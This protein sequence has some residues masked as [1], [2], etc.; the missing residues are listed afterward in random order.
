MEKDPAQPH[1]DFTARKQDVH[2]TQKL[3]I[4]RSPRVLSLPCSAPTS[5]HPRESLSWLTHRQGFT[6]LWRLN[7]MESSTIYIV[8]SA[9]MLVK[10]S[11]ICPSTITVSRK[12]VSRRHILHWLMHDFVAR[13]C[14]VGVANGARLTWTPRR[15]PRRALT[16]SICARPA[17]AH[18][19]CSDHTHP[20]LVSQPP[21]CRQS[22]SATPQKTTSCRPSD[23]NFETLPKRHIYCSI[24]ALKKNKQ[25]QFNV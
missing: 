8:S 17:S 10:K 21:L 24:Y 6:W 12:D 7:K 11:H 13:N 16:S 4:P 15:N 25:K 1:D 5:P 18:Y 23:A 22:P 20:H 9:R 3:H 19:V 14:W 2:G